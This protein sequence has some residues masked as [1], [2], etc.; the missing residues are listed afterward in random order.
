MLKVKKYLAVKE[1]VLNKTLLTCN[2]SFVNK[3]KDIQKSVDKFRNILSKNPTMISTIDIRKDSGGQFRICKEETTGAWLLFLANV[4]VYYIESIN[5]MNAFSKAFEN[6]DYIFRVFITTSHYIVFCLSCSPPIEEV[7]PYCIASHI[8]LCETIGSFVI[9]NEHF[10]DKACTYM[11]NDQFVIDIVEPEND[12]YMLRKKQILHY[13]IIGK[14][15]INDNLYKM[16]ELMIQIIRNH[17]FLPEHY[18]N[19]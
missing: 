8:I 16:S 14:G 18:L 1:N 9:L 13:K 2:N 6:S 4:S 12:N 5:S 17:N 11:Y 19:I 3:H 10:L 15:L 7:V